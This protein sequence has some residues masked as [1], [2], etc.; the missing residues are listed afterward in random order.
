GLSAALRGVYSSLHCL[1]GVRLLCFN[2][3]QNPGLV[4]HYFSEAHHVRLAYCPTA[5]GTEAR[6]AANAT[7][8]PTGASISR[9]D[10]AGTATFSRL[11]RPTP[12]SSNRT[13][14]RIMY[15]RPC[16]V[17]TRKKK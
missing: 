2:L 11:V 7:P 9:V 3:H 8:S 13:D 16:S 17:P 15:S 6:Q 5:T 1:F 4:K 14:R 12:P 10:T